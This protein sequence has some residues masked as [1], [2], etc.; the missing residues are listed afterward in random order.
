MRKAQEKGCPKEN[1]ARCLVIPVACGGRV[2]V[3][4]LGLLF[5]FLNPKRNEEQTEILEEKH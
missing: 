1:H 4:L 3:L 5:P 2:V